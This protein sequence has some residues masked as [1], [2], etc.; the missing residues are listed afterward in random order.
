MTRLGRPSFPLTFHDVTET[1]GIEPPDAFESLL[2]Q[3]INLLV[4]GHEPISLSN[5]T[6]LL[7]DTPDICLTS[8]A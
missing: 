2:Q 3:V 6:Q 8:V 1:A 4:N 7:L 5:R